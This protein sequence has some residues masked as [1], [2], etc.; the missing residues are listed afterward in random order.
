MHTSATRHT[1]Q[2]RAEGGA[3]R[4]ADGGSGGE[5][6][7]L[8]VGSVEDSCRVGQLG[9]WTGRQMPVGISGTVYQQCKQLPSEHVFAPHT[10]EHAQSVRRR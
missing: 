2:A 10:R 5:A 6:S 3:L 1:R 9:Y 8:R 4:Q 7:P